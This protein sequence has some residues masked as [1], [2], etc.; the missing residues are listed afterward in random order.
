MKQFDLQKALEGTPVQLRN[1][2][3]AFVTLFDSSDERYPL[4]VAEE[5]L[6]NFNQKYV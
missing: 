4:S 6:L 2:S 3:K 5:T 1:G